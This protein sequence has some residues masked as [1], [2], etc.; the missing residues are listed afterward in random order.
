MAGWNSTICNCDPY[1]QRC[2]ACDI[3]WSNIRADFSPY[4]ASS[5]SSADAPA[6][7]PAQIMQEQHEAAA[8]ADHH[9]TVEDTIDE[10]DI[11]HPPPP[12]TDGPTPATNGTMSA[13]AAGKQKATETLG[14]LDT[15][16]EEAFPSLG[17]AP[18]PAPRA[19]GWGANSA[20]KSPKPNG[21]SSRPTSSGVPTPSSTPG[22]RTPTTNVRGGVNLPGRFRDQFEIDNRDLDK[23]KTT[24]KVLD[25]AKKKFNVLVSTKPVGFASRT[26][27]IAEGIKQRSV[28]EALMYIS[29]EITVDKT[30]T[31]DIPTAVSS[32]II[33][34]GGANIKKLEAQFNVRIQIDK[35][36]KTAGPDMAIVVIKG[37]A[38]GVRQVYE[39]ISNQAKALQPKVDL[40]VRDIPPELFPFLAGTHGPRIQKMQQDRDL[41]ID[42]PDFFRRQQT[43]PTRDEGGPLFSPHGNSY[44]SISGDQAAA[45]QAQ[46]ELMRLA[47]QLQE[48]LILEEL[49]AELILHPYIVGDRGMD[50]LE[51]LEQT[52]CAVILPPHHHDTEEIHIIGPRDRIS[53]GTDLA[54]ELMSKKHN[55]AVDLQKQFQDA[56]QGHE[57]HSRALAQ[58]LQRKAIE[59]EFMNSHNAEVLFPRH[60]S[61]PP[62]WNVMTD[63]PTKAMAA[64]NELAK[65][66][67]AYPTSRLQLVEIDPFFHPHL[68]QLHADPFQEMG[69]H[70]IVPDNGEDAV[71]LVYEGPTSDSPFA[72]PRTKPTPS[73]IKEFEKALQEAEARLMASIPHQGISQAELNVPRKHQDRVRKFTNNYPKPTRENSFPVQ[74]D[75]GGRQKRNDQV[76]LR[77]PEES[78]IDALQKAI[79]QFLIEVE[80][81]EKERSH[82]TTFEFP[83]KFNKNLI[84]K[85]GQNINAL[86]EKHDVDIDTRESG[87]V[88]IQGPPKKAEAC[89]AEILKTLKQWEDEVNY[90][91][92]IEPKYHGMLVGRNGENLK[93]LQTN[94]GNTVRIDFPRVSKAADDASVADTAS[95]VG[96]SR[97]AA[98]EVRIRGPRAKADQVRS[99]LL[100]LKAYMEETSFTASVSVDS[101]QVGSLIGRG[102][103]EVEKLRADTGAQI[104]VP[105]DKSGPRAAIQIKGTKQQVDKAKAELLKRAK[106]YDSIVTQTVDVD[107][108]HHRTL[109]GQGGES[110]PMFED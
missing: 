72:F 34:R 69:V 73:E 23:S 9:A 79:E 55:R 109:I 52:G 10:E 48:Q 101:K 95:E 49:T 62:S 7:T 54:N 59:R 16:D 30:E 45:R 5:S 42:I 108:K 13:K 21:T 96:G 61:A 57:R 6:K 104:D 56:P 4:M 81:D 99:E 12:H 43:P 77:G 67:Q 15:Q 90:V 105:K 68:D 80:E 89:K 18:K 100:D 2:R 46:Q 20:V 3:F 63:D 35:D 82:T 88:K 11:E 24:K 26:A 78:D 83:V 74:V 25:D 64:R 103:I 39:Q 93:R 106:A 50:P 84:G 33:G 110:V 14:V 8:A 17:P 38:A 28:T 94:T 27:F 22:I 41:Q 87:K 97:Q 70:M 29:K 53:R 31:L 44:I 107:R 40:P 37:H 32:Q 71:V 86:R 102:G 60:A 75:F 1:H 76:I 47:Q 66:A 92:K 36:S 19:G 65:I 58:Y 98:D 51:F 91:I 85:G